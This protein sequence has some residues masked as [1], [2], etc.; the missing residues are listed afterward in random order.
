ME[1][2]KVDNQGDSNGKNV[3]SS[4]LEGKRGE[5]VCKHLFQVVEVIRG[6]KWQI[7]RNRSCGRKIPV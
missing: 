4:I 3:Y 1:N 6:V 2:K 7:C 5:E